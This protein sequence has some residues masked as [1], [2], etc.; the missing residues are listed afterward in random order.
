[1]I[2]PLQYVQLFVNGPSFRPLKVLC[3][4]CAE[5][6]LQFYTDSFETLQMLYVMV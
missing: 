5:L 3:T 1:M 2:G 6:L 4:L